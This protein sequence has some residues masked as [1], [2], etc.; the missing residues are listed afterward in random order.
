MREA[1]RLKHPEAF[2]A[3]N[4]SEDISKQ[5]AHNVKKMHVPVLFLL[6]FRVIS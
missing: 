4:H 3:A 5:K 6:G 1:T 2:S